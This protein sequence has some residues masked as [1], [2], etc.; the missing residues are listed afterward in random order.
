M[1]FVEA[2]LAAIAVPPLRFGKHESRPGPLPPLV[3]NYQ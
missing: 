2:A 3:S 1:E